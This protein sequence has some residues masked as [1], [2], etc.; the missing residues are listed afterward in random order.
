MDNSIEQAP[1]VAKTKSDTFVLLHKNARFEITTSDDLM[2][3]LM[4]IALM[5]SPSSV[6]VDDAIRGVYIH[7]LYRASTY[8]FAKDELDEMDLGGWAILDVNGDYLILIP[9]IIANAT[10]VSL[11]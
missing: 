3:V 6:S 5:V 10:G 7:G 8:F 9:E 4:D 11:M 2:E 1:P